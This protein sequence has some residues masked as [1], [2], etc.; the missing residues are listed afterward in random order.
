MIVLPLF[1]FY[2]FIDLPL[3]TKQKESFLLPENQ[4]HSTSS[5]GLR[6]RGVGDSKDL[7]PMLAHSG[8]IPQI[9]EKRMC[10]RLESDFALIKKM[11]QRVQLH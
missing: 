7:V 3:S 11:E 9:N 4:F 10:P 1:S 5:T 6:A 2:R 8:P